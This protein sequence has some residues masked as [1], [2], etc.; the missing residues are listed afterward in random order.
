MLS[1]PT[2]RHNFF[3]VIQIHAFDA[4]RCAENVR[5][6][7]DGQMLFEHREEP[8]T[9]FGFAV[10]VNGGFFNE[11]VEPTLAQRGMRG[12]LPRSCRSPIGL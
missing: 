8:D 7:G 10:R 6:K 5:R 12:P 3:S 1:A 11:F 9:L 4:D 2:D